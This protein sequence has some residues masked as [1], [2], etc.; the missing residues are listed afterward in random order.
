MKKGKLYSAAGDTVRKIV[1]RLP[2]ELRARAEAV[3]VFYEDSPDPLMLTD[4]IETDTLGMFVGRTVDDDSD[5]SGII[6]PK[7]VIY[8]MNIFDDAEG[9]M[10]EFREQVRIT[11]LHEL[12][13]FLGLDEKGLLERDLD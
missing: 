5:T 6:P 10:S 9:D 1:S 8:V 2:G 7:I 4:G 13:H 12:G 11:Y 3:P